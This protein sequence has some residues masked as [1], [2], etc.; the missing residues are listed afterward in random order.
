M[1]NAPEPE[2]TRFMDRSKD[3]VC[4]RWNV[5]STYWNRGQALCSRVKI[6]QP[7]ATGSK[8]Y[9]ADLESDF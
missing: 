9:T 4:I 1:K 7:I 2:M 8:S 6:H 5:Y 3:E